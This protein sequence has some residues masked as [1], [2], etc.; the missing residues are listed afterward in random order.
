MRKQRRRQKRIVRR[1]RAIRQK[2]LD[3][4]LEDRA[5]EPIRNI[6]FY[7]PR[8]NG[9]TRF[10]LL[11]LEFEVPLSQLKQAQAE[12]KRVS[13]QRDESISQ[14]IISK[15]TEELLEGAA[16]KFKRSFCFGGNKRKNGSNYV[17]IHCNSS[18]SSKSLAS[19]YVTSS[20]NAGRNNKSLAR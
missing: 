20:N 5:I 6:E 18:I 4:G 15:K 17:A 7:C 9:T 12:A 1:E 13:K 11:H 8:I 10:K 3:E 14:S 19:S 16:R 2:Y